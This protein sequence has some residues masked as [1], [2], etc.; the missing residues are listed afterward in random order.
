M[1]NLN[2]GSE[3]L[4]RGWVQCN[5]NLISRRL[6]GVKSCRLQLH[7]PHL[8]PAWF[9]LSRVL[10]TLSKPQSLRV[11]R[12]GVPTP[13]LKSDE[14]EPRSSEAVTRSPHDRYR[15]HTPCPPN[16]RSPQ[17]NNHPALIP[18]PPP[19]PPCR[20]KRTGLLVLF[21]KLL[22]HVASTRPLPFELRFLPE[23]AAAP[24]GRSAPSPDSVL[25]D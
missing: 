15:P 25:S 12:A 21:V 1:C 5:L 20:Q 18:L 13:L 10:P 4:N 11:K 19:F 23:G 24:T 17:G 14:A 3:D 9:F 22:D 6:R 8:H 7:S 2:W 16:V